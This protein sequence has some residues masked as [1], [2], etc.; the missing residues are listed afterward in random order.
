[1]GKIEYKFGSQKK[2]IT[3]LELSWKDYCKS[4][5]LGFKLQNPNGSAFT[6]MTDFIM[7]Y[8][9]K[10]EQDMVKWKESSKSLADFNDEVTQCFIAITDHLK[11]K[12]K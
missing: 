10:K 3:V 8:T 6:D 4:T 12:K 11:S 2:E 9:G 5:D 7:L 1:M